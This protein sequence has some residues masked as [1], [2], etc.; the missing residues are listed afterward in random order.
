MVLAATLST[1]LHWMWNVCS[2][3]QSFYRMG[4]INENNVNAKMPDGDQVVQWYVPSHLPKC[5]IPQ[6]IVMESSQ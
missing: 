2:L 6:M 3:Q 1:T 5:K 4:H